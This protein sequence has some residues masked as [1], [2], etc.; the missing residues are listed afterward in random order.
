MSMTRRNG[1]NIDA[2]TIAE[3]MCVWYANNRDTDDNRKKFYCGITNDP[4]TR[5]DTHKREDH[6]G[7]EIEKMLVYECDNVD[8]A[9][10][11]ESIMGEKGFDIGNPRYPGN[12]A[13]DDSKYV[14]LY[15]KP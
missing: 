14:Y 1:K 7:R 3:L 8:I 13:A 2:K 11:T 4:E 10:E 9:T 5:K 6:G 12:G 15:R